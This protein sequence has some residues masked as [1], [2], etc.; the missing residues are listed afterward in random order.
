MVI[1]DILKLIN[2]FYKALNIYNIID[3][4]KLALIIRNNVFFNFIGNKKGIFAD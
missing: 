3:Y 1:L 2:N 4:N